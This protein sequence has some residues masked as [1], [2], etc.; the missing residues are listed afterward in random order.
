MHR[1]HERLRELGFP[2]VPRVQLSLADYQE[3]PVE[4]CQQ[5][6]QAV[7]R[8]L[9]AQTRV[10]VE[11]LTSK[12]REATRVTRSPF[13]TAGLTPCTGTV[14]PLAGLTPLSFAMRPQQLNRKPIALSVGL[15]ISA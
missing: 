14:S 3:D 15:L 12:A 1:T 4:A 9:E 2:T 11:E 6:A 8:Q 7:A 10:E 5:W 13:S